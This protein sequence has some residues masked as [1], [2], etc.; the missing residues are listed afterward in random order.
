MPMPFVPI[1]VP[2][3]PW[4]WE[5]EM[6]EKASRILENLTREA[7]EDEDENPDVP[8]VFLSKADFDDKCHTGEYLNLKEYGDLDED[9]KEAFELVQIYDEDSEKGYGMRY[10]RRN[11]MKRNIEYKEKFFD[12]AEDAAEAATALGCSGAHEADGKFLPCENPEEYAKRA[13]D[14]AKGAGHVAYV[15][16]LAAALT[17]LWWGMSFVTEAAP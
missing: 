4:T 8:S 17:L 14:W 6:A 11:P 9:A 12:S 1:A 3:V 7:D 5:A 13:L 2:N 15:I 10:R 16:G